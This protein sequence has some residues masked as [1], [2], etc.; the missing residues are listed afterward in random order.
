METTTVSPYIC[1][2]MPASRCRGDDTVA[3]RLLRGHRTSS[4][5]LAT[6][7]RDADTEYD[8]QQTP[9]PGRGPCIGGRVWRDRSHRPV[10]RPPASAATAHRRRAGCWTGRPAVSVVRGSVA[11]CGRPGFE[12]SVDGRLRAAC[13]GSVRSPAGG[14]SCWAAPSTLTSAS[15][16]GRRRR[17]RRCSRRRGHV[18]FP[19]FVAVTRPPPLLS[20]VRWASS[21]APIC[22]RGRYGG[23][24]RRGSR[25]RSPRVPANGRRP[26]DRR[27]PPAKLHRRWVR[28]VVGSPGRQRRTPNQALQQTAGARRLSQRPSSCGP[29]RG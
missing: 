11:G 8:L 16:A 6:D 19:R 10:A 4:G 13:N 9:T 7:A 29:R 14:S 18:G 17:T 12:N 28:P 1:E 26:D 24:A 15:G 27:G 22:G 25:R 3:G 5:Y 20:G 2:R 21:P 23:T